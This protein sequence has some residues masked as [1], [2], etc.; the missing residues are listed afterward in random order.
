MNQAIRTVLTRLEIEA[1]WENAQKIPRAT[2]NL[3]DV[4]RNLVQLVPYA[5]F[6]GAADDWAR[7]DV[8]RMTPE[9]LQKNLKWVV[10]AFDDQL[11]EWLAGSEASSREPSDAYVAFS[12]MR[13]AADFI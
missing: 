11:D 1:A 9:F 7:E 8:I 3:K 10:A 4:P 6:W 2:F 12:A 13:M 5:E